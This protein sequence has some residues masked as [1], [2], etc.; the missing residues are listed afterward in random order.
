ME[1]GVCAFLPVDDVTRLLMTCREYSHLPLPYGHLVPGWCNAAQAKQIAM[2]H[3]GH[4]KSLINVHDLCYNL[5]CELP[6]G[7]VFVGTY[8]TQ[9]PLQVGEDLRASFV[10]LGLQDV[11]DVCALSNGD[12]VVATAHHT[13]RYKL[14]MD[15]VSDLFTTR[16]FTKLRSVRSHRIVYGVDCTIPGTRRVVRVT[17]DHQCTSLLSMRNPIITVTDTHLYVACC[18]DPNRTLYCMKHE[19]VVLKPMCVLPCSIVQIRGMPNGSLAVRCS[20]MKVHLFTGDLKPVVFDM[21]TGHMVDVGDAIYCATR[22]LCTT[23]RR[24]YTHKSGNNFIGVC[25]GSLL[26]L[27]KSRYV[28]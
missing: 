20:N 9:M 21:G 4:A 12:V 23:T 24:L 14:H 3:G 28:I 19:E 16:T 2:L 1:F 8:N 5:C 25:S 6:S 27:A 26:A 10:Y 22:C 7:A 15:A 18:L 17:E 11:V 13:R